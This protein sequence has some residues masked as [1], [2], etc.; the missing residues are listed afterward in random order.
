MSADIGEWLEAARRLFPSLARGNG[1][2]IIIAPTDD[3]QLAHGIELRTGSG[4]E[5]P[6]NQ[7]IELREAATAPRQCA[8]EDLSATADCHEITDVV[9]VSP[10]RGLPLIEP[11]ELTDQEAEVLE[12]LVRLKQKM[13]A[14]EIAPKASRTNDS[15]FRGFL[16]RMRTQR[17]LL[18]NTPG[19]GY[20]PT[21]LGL[22]SLWA[23]RKVDLFTVRP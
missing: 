12:V 9:E 15:R 21:I 6:A 22:E 1:L 19:S 8:A 7:V 14:K 23:H 10:V 20:F 13:Q 3:M 18:D 4:A 17:K 11:I 5:L 2:R 16:G